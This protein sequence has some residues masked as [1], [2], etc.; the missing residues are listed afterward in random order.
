MRVKRLE[1][2]NFRRIEQATIIFAPATFI[3]GPNNTA[4]SSIVAA[5]EALLSLV[6]EKLTQEDILVNPNGTRA[7]VTTLTA[8]FGEIP[9]DVASSRGFRGRVVNDE[10]VYRKSLSTDTTKPKIETK[11]YPSTIKNEFSNAK[12]F[13]DLINKGIS[14]EILRESLEFTDSNGKLPRNWH[15]SLPEVLEF[16]MLATPEWIVNPGGIPQ[17]VLSRLPRL[18]HIPPLTEAKEI[19][20]G[21]K[22]YALGECLSLL[23][24]DLLSITPVAGEIQDKLKELEKQ[25]DPDDDTTQICTLIKEINR[26]IADVFP[27]CGIRIEPS[28]QNL[29][30]ILRPKYDIKVFSNIPTS[31]A[32]QGTGLIRTCSFAMLRYHAKLKIEKDLQTRP[33]LVTFE[34]PELFL[35]PSAANLLRDTIYS[36]GASDQIVC[37]THSP[38]MIDLS[39]NPQSITKMT[40]GK[41]DFAESW[42]YGVSSVYGELPSDDRDRVR[43]LQIFDDEM[44][45][46]FFAEEVL[47]V[48]GDS[49]VL[50]IKQTLAL[51]PQEQQKDIVARYQIIKARGKSTIISLVKYL[52]ALGIKPIVMH[53]GDYGITGAE[54]FNKPILDAVGS[55]GTIVILDPNLE[56]TL[57]YDPPDVDKPYKAFKHTG[58]WGSCQNIPQAWRDAICKIFGIIWPK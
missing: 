46:I 36:L 44:S 26:I 21:E 14:V 7:N 16:D 18:I 3:V 39:Q 23:F 34:E 13:T 45:R 24:E 56:K 35:H 33:V 37:T 17:N 15:K 20:S 30:E 10:Y 31:V 51:L 27:K 2:T 58:S 25:M 50:A 52:G 29:L 41:T 57:G 53:D 54:K 43:M 48:E 6:T 40:L 55:N 19:E 11:E 32:R 1:I 28:L 49:E 12:T 42:N 4:K 22:K 8:Y 38:W 9:P 47:V 5:L